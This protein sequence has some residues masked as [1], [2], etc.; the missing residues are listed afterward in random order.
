MK[1]AQ[2]TVDNHPV[3]ELENVPISDLG[4][5]AFDMSSTASSQ[6]IIDVLKP[7][8]FNREKLAQISNEISGK[9]LLDGVNKDH[10]VIDNSNLLVVG[11]KKGKL[12][13]VPAI[14]IF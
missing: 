10:R 5:L 3:D 9:V 2:F 1:K 4:Q 12:Q 8:G 6:K 11:V 13:I 7:F 14:D